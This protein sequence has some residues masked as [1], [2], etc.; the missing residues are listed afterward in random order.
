MYQS[1]RVCPPHLNS[2]IHFHSLLLQL[3]IY[4]YI[5]IYTPKKGTHVLLLVLRHKLSY[6]TNSLDKRG[7]GLRVLKMK[8]AWQAWL[9]KAFPSG[10]GAILHP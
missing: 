9:H 10:C 6:C 5:Y 8:T 3:S 4:P 2:T 1:V 7:G